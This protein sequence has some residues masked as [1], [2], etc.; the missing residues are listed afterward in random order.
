MVEHGNGEVTRVDH[1]STFTKDLPV[2]AEE[3]PAQLAHQLRQS[4]GKVTRGELM[5]E[6][7]G[8]DQ[9]L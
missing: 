6:H 5:S 7:V 9:V 8:E 4:A 2:D 1:Y 3:L